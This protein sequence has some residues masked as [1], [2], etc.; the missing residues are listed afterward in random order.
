MDAINYQ[1]RVSAILSTVNVLNYL[2]Q[3]LL[4]NITNVTKYKLKCKL[5]QGVIDLK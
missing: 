4:K 5:L 2:I 1:L 3:I